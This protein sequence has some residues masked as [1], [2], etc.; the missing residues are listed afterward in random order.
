MV[1]FMSS[2]TPSPG[3]FM[4]FE[5]R[6]SWGLWAIKTSGKR[7][8]PLIDSPSQ[9][10]QVNLLRSYR[11]NLPFASTC[12]LPF[13]YFLWEGCFQYLSQELERASSHPLCVSIKSVYLNP[14]ERLKSRFAEMSFLAFRSSSLSFLAK[15]IMVRDLFFPVRNGE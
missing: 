15:I 5:S 9:S 2:F 6:T 8:F 4:Q 7:H 1:P 13:D 14:L 10:V 3:L 11:T 12:I